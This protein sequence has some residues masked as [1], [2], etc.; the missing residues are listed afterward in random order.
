M[1][2]FAGNSFGMFC[3]MYP[4]YQQSQM[5]HFGSAPYFAFIDIEEGQIVSYYAK[6]NESAKLS[7]KK[8]LQAAHLL[9]GENVDVVLAAS[10]GE[11]P[12]HVLGDSII[13]IYHLSDSVNIRDAVLLLNQNLLKIMES[14]IE[15][16]ENDEIE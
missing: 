1:R 3:K 10:L 15:K 14:P 11:G 8:G 16:H 6:I 13:Q 7:H 12:F 9:V 5:L 4:Q 2:H